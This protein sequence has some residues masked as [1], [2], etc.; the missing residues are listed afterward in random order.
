[1]V[2]ITG[3][4]IIPKTL[5]DKVTKK[6]K[7]ILEYKKIIE[8]NFKSDISDLVNVVLVGAIH[9]GASDIHFEPREEDVRLRIRIDGMLQDVLNL[10]KEIYRFILS[11]IKLL[12]GLKLNI[13][14]RPKMEVFLLFCQPV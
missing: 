13:H 3:K 14:D 9:L 2:K 10:P 6:V 4:T 1:M 5:W 11:R 8:Q 7:H 12:A